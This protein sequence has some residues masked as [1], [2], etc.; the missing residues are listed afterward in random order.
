M[1]VSHVLT[2]VVSPKIF[3]GVVALA[4]H[5]NAIEMSHEHLIDMIAQEVHAAKSTS[6]LT[7]GSVDD[8]VLWIRERRTRPAMSAQV[9]R[10]LMTLDFIFGFEPT[11][12]ISAGVLLRRFVEPGLH[13]P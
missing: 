7:V 9:K 11:W 12:T 4:E 6:T 8:S 2:E 5:V 3:L 10:I 13:Q 1:R